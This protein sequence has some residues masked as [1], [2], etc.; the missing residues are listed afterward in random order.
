MGTF[1][2]SVLTIDDGVFEVKSTAGDTH[3]GGSD[4]DNALTQH[5]LG[6]FVKR[7]RRSGNGSLTT[8]EVAKNAR[9]LR[10]L[11]SACERAKRTLSSQTQATI[12]VESFY[13]G[14]D[15]SE[16]ITRARF[17]EINADMFRNILRPVEQALTDAKLSK[18]DIDDIVMVGGSSRIP[19]VQEMLKAYFNG[20]TL[21]QSI[22]PDEAVAYGA[23]IQG[24]ILGGKDKTTEQMVLLDV[25]PLSLGLETAGG[26]MTKIIERNTTIPCNKKEVFSTYADNQPGVL[27]QVFEGERQ[28]TR[29][30]N[31]LGKFD[32]TG[33]A[34]APRGVPQIEVTFDV[35]AN[36]IMNVTALDKNTGKSNK[37]AITNDKGRLSKEEIEKMVAEAEKFAKEDGEVKERIDAR[38]AL[39]SVCYAL[40]ESKEAP[41]EVKKE[42]EKVEEWLRANEHATTSELKDKLKE[43]QTHAQTAASGTNF[44]GGQSGP[45]PQHQ[46]KG[47]SVEEVD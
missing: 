5:I 31:L 36:G 16:V 46:T 10:R 35:D 33:I 19:K 12:E 11:L 25:I 26:V 3:L 47:P 20:K 8:T 22:N 28:L 7:Q 6:E 27:I 45:P 43:L 37:I 2:V 23:A 15:L 41:A 18:K 30:N 9:A 44:D 29:Y 4:F 34:P 24:S 39:E 14:I 13:E 17:E 38:N 40:K 1:D 42:A 21:C 32:L